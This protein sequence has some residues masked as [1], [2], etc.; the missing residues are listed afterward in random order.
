MG[1]NV[2]ETCFVCVCVLNARRFYSRRFSLAGRPGKSLKLNQK[3]LPVRLFIHETAKVCRS[4]ACLSSSNVSLFFFFLSSFFFFIVPS[5][6]VSRTL[7]MAAF[8]ISLFF[9]F[10]FRRDQSVIGRRFPMAIAE[11][12]ETLVRAVRRRRIDLFSRRA[13]KSPFSVLSLPFSCEFS[14]STSLHYV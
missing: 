11:M 3:R 2:N 13:R 8:K 7:M 12:A 10:C 6:Q 4:F 5:V 1:L 14:S 9:C